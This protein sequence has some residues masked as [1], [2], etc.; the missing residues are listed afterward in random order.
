MRII[1]LL[2]PVKRMGSGFLEDNP[3]PGQNLGYDDGNALEMALRIK[4]ET[5][6]DVEIIVLS[7]GPKE[8][9]DALREA[10]ALGADKACLVTDPALEGADTVVTARCLAAAIRKTGAYDMVLAG[11]KSQDGKTGHIGP[12]VAEYLGVPQITYVDECRLINGAVEAVSGWKDQSMRIRTSL[13]CCLVVNKK[14][15][16]LRCMT[17][18]GVRKAMKMSITHW[19]L[20]DLGCC[21]NPCQSKTVVLNRLRNQTER[22]HIIINLR[23]DNSDEEEKRKQLMTILQT[24]KTGYRTLL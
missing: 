21:G 7:M 23:D 22:K 2:K 17:L 4:D 1:V 8:G 20:P 16:S 18:Q 13:P 15:F 10:L 5:S 14:R 3:M 24:I 6:K 11:Y 12:M 9:E 19:P